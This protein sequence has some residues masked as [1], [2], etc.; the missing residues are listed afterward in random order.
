MEYSTYMEISLEKLKNYI[1]ESEKRPIIFV[2]AGLSRRYFDSP[3]WSELIERLFED[4]PNIEKP[5]Q[6]YLQEH[7]GN[8]LEV[9]SVLVDYYRDYYWTDNMQKSSPKSLYE[10]NDKSIFLKY[11]IATIINEHYNEFDIDTNFYKEE[12]ALL[13]KLTPEA[14]ITTNYDKF[15]DDIFSDYDVMVGQNS[16]YDRK[17]T[18]SFKILKIHGSVDDYEKIVINKDD[19]EKFTETQLYLTAKLLTYFIE[20]PVVFIGYSLSDDNVKIILQNIKKIMN[21]TDLLMENM[22]FI[23]YVVD[24]EKNTY[25]EDR[26]RYPISDTESVGMNYISVTSF[27]ELYAALY[28]DSININSLKSIEN[29]MYNLVKSSSITNLEVDVANVNFIE[30]PKNL[31]ELMTRKDLFFNMSQITDANLASLNYPYTP[32]LLSKE[33]FEDENSTWQEVYKLIY[34][35]EKD[36]NIKLRET[37]SRYHIVISGN[38]HRYSGE[39]LSLLKKEVNG[40]DYN[41]EI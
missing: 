4:N 10:N 6:Y 8:L 31:L 14:I 28:Q 35:I 40:E 9:A 26:K 1:K 25:F 32:T 24:S 17:S 2:G 34:K 11:H 5:V 7:K 3:K 22:W 36:N 19:Y 39:M 33:V 12:I 38:I 16:V 13:K 27:K 37:N 21:E 30:E 23:D 29:T 20:H 18:N 15:L 41:I